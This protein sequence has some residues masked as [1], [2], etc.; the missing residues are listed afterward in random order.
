MAFRLPAVAA[1]LRKAGAVT[2]LGT[3]LDETAELA[4]VV[5]PTDSPLETG[6]DYEPYAGVH[7]LIQPTTARLYDSRNAGNNG[8]AGTDAEPRNAIS[9]P[10]RITTDVS[11]D[12]LA[13]VIGHRPH[14]TRR[15][16]HRVRADA[17]RNDA[18]TREHGKAEKTC[19]TAFSASPRPR[20]SAS[21]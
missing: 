19:Q 4:D 5:L 7:G 8:I 6:G 3:H 2:Y 12:T 15:T 13:V 16:S 17:Y 1:G 20:V 9:L 10:V 14:R 18:E 21:L 11:L